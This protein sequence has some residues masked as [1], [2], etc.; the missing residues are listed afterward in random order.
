MNGK[1]AVVTGASSGI[2][3]A[4]VRA[5]AVEG[6][7]VVA[8]LAVRSVSTSSSRGYPATA[9]RL[10]RLSAMLLMSSTPT[11]SFVGRS[12][13]SEVSTSLSTTRA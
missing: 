5:L 10:S 4:T 1:V 13:S 2:G 7:A 6:A 11:T 12:R 9:G 8:G 3:E